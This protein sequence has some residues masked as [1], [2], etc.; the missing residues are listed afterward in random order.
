[1]KKFLLLSA[2][3]FAGLTAS[4]NDYFDVKVEG[5]VIADG[6]T[7]TIKPEYVE[8]A[9]GIYYMQENDLDLN[10]VSKKGTMR[11]VIVATCTDPGNDAVKDP[12]Y[13]MYQ[14]CFTQKHGEPGNCLANSDES[15]Y[16]TTA[17]TIETDTF[18]WQIH[19]FANTFQTSDPATYFK[20]M[21]V[22]LDMYACDGTAENAKI[23]EA[24]KYTIY[25]T[26]TFDNKGDGVEV[27]AD[28]AAA[29]YFDMQGRK[30][31]QPESGLYIVKRG[32]KVTKEFVR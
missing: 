10:I 28:D 2:L 11:Q 30:V 31:A 3:A 5:E 18:L 13:G 29:V 7:V 22:R 20:P 26:Y 17:A 24:S 14:I 15:T 27:V 19:A 4:A 6:E 25:S 8:A 16:Y 32:N 23:I 1:M 9:P 12:C 21:T